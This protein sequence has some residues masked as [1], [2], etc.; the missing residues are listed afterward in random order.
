MTHQFVEQEKKLFE[1]NLLSAHIC[2]K[3]LLTPVE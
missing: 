1:W 3:V 2:R